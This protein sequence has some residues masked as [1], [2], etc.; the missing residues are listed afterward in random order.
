VKP[1]ELILLL[2][3]QIC[4]LEKHTV[5]IIGL[6]VLPNVQSCDTV[7]FKEIPLGG[8]STVKKLMFQI[9]IEF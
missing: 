7:L 8:G 1:S 6:S 9:Q 3:E 4:Y 5:C 2:L